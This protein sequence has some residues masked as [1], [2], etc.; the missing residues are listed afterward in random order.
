MCDIEVHNHECLPMAAALLASSSVVANPLIIF[1]RFT[2]GGVGGR[3]AGG[4]GGLLRLL[5]CRNQNKYTVSTSWCRHT[6]FILFKL[7]EV[8]RSYLVGQLGVIVRDS[9]K[10]GAAK[11]TRQEALSIELAAAIGSKMG[12]VDPNQWLHEGQQGELLSGEKKREQGKG[13]G[14][15]S[16]QTM[17]LQWMFEHKPPES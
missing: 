11:G 2:G 3:D 10:R 13:T 1:C 16:V 4:V 17:V 6:M 12:K 9:I 14:V 7:S 5:C 8:S 15:K